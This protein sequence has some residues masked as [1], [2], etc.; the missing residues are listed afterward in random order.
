MMHVSYSKWAA[1]Q[2]IAGYKVS[3][4]QVCRLAL[5]QKGLLSSSSDHRRIHI[6]RFWPF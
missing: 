1:G 3:I 2:Y 5:L 4:G 6:G